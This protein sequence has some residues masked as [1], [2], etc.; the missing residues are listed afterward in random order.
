[1]HESSETLA[2]PERALE[3]RDNRVAQRAR[4][5][6]PSTGFG[7]KVDAE[8]VRR[9]LSDSPAYRD[10]P[11]ETKRD[12]VNSLVLIHGGILIGGSTISAYKAIKSV[13]G[14]FTAPLRDGPRLAG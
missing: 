6:L 3:D 10:V 14:F 12:I 11:D 9:L 8:T 4:E 7:Q 2:D 13:Y 5:S 1:M